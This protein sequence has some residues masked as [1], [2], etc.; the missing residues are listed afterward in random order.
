MVI[1]KFEYMKSTE[2]SAIAMNG[3]SPWGRGSALDA[4]VF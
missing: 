2:F 3:C 1:I 4:Y